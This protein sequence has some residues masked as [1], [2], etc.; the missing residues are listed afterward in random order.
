MCFDVE[1]LQVVDITAS[2]PNKPGQ[3]IEASMLIGGNPKLLVFALV[4]GSAK[5]FLGKHGAIPI[6]ALKD[7]CHQLEAIGFHPAVV[8]HSMAIY[9]LIVFN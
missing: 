6:G 2:F 4:F 3:I 1:S 8:R 5:E 9:L 7:K